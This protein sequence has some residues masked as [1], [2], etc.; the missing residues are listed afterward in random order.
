MGIFLARTVSFDRFVN[1]VEAMAL[2]D[3]LVMESQGQDPGNTDALWHPPGNGRFPLLPIREGLVGTLS[4]KQVIG[5]AMRASQ[6]EGGVAPM[7]LI[8]GVEVGLVDW[9]SMDAADDDTRY[10]FRVYYLADG[11]VGGF[12]VEA[13]P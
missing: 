1:S 8:D 12:F 5:L 9:M 13:M 6:D 4:R 2:G 11:E 3:D 7:F 10:L